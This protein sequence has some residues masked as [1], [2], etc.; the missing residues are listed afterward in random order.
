MMAD[1]TFLARGCW[2]AAQV[3]V[4]VVASTYAPS[5]EQIRDIDRVWVDACA[6]PGVNLFDGPLCRLESH[7]SDHAHLHLSVS[8]CSYKQFYG[9]NGTHSQWADTHG[10]AC[11]ANAVGTS[12]ALVSGDGWLVFGRRAESLA[13]YP[14]WAHPF[15]GILEPSDDIDLLNEMQRELHEEI[16]LAA[17]DL[18]DLACIGLVR[19]PHLMQPELLYVA[20][21][22]L[23]LATLEQ[24]LDAGEHSA[25]WCVRADP[26]A[27]AVALHHEFLTPVTRLVLQRFAEIL[28]LEQA[29][30]TGNPA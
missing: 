5:P 23:S 15:G 20:R 17:T 4:Q 14:G 16:G 25:C 6:R 8:Q 10:W 9:T 12:A 22:P 30:E 26:S 2:R 19:D 7:S 24:R 18:S 21:T 27:I 3:S 1:S 28:E 11:L 13:L 29:T